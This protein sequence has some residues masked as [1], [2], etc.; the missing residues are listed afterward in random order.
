MHKYGGVFIA[1]EHMTPTG[2]DE[3]EL[4]TVRDILFG[5]KSREHEQRFDDAILEKIE[6]E[7][8]S[9]QERAI[10]MKQRLQD[11]TGENIRRMNG[12]RWSVFPRRD[13]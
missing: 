10:D 5:E 11:L 7:H 8:S 13:R 4:N 12:M 1:D 3:N 9:R 6:I 2:M